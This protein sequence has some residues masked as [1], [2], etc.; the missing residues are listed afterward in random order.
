MKTLGYVRVSTR[1]QKVDRQLTQLYEICDR[2]YEEHGV[3]AVARSRPVYE[4][5]IAD[6][7]PGGT[8]VVTAVDRVYRSSVDALTEL[9]KLQARG[10]HFRSLTLNL[11]TR[12][13]DGRLFY[14]IVS[15]MAEWERRIISERTK[16]GL[17]VARRKG[18][19]LG[20]PRKLDGNKLAWARARLKS[21]D[22]HVTFG[23]LSTQLGVDRKTL[24]RALC[25]L[26]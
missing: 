17:A 7:E 26:N 18:K 13:P 11:D 15:A 22:P 12:T 3:S 16:Q 21:N 6:L 19:R 25:R 14:T 20:R 24:R 9:D 1:G 10:I 23:L 4:Q 8:F 2:V 5:A